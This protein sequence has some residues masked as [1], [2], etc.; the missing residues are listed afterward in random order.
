[1][2]KAAP[3]KKPASI[4]LSKRA[5]MLYLEHAKVVQ[6]DGRVLYLTA[7]TEKLDH[8]FNIPHHNTSFVMLGKGTSITDSAARML[9]D[10]NVMVGFCGSGGSPMFSGS[11]FTFLS[12]Q[13]E[14]RPTEYMQA[15]IRMWL[16]DAKRLS[17]AKAFLKTR[18]QWTED[19]WDQ[20]K[21]LLSKK[22]RF[23]EHAA[24][25]LRSALKNVN[26][27]EALLSAE[28]QWA[29][30]AYAVLASG[31]KINNFTR[32]ESPL[33]DGSAMALVNSMLN[34]GNYLAYGLSAVAL[35][36]LGISFALPVLHG[37][38]RR[39]GL[40]FDVADLFK[41]F[42]SMPMA[43][44]HGHRFSEEGE[45]RADLMGYMQNEDLFDRTIDEIKKAI[46]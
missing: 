32:Q 10:A 5:H 43:F 46:R 13:E 23:P 14:Y 33:S 3:P 21:E 28:G 38:T 6:K 16:D 30:A 19:A 40:V 7:G 17:V 15:W 12:P 22:I 9:A 44:I 11:D 4:M 35:H 37:N 41:D 36:A 26:T 2:K 8:F 18:L 20:N 34:H 1:M 25:N 29:K 24:A 45:F 31:F 27:T 39:G 42:T